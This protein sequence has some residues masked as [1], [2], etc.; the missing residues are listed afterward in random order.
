MRRLQSLKWRRA[1][2]YVGGVSLL[3]LGAYLRFFVFLKFGSGALLVYAAAGAGALLLGV[4]RESS[5]AIKADGLP[6]GAKSLRRTGGHDW[7]S[8]SAAIDVVS[9]GQRTEETCYGERILGYLATL[10]YFYRNPD[11]QMGEYSRM[12]DAE[13]DAQTWAASNKGRTVMVH[14]DPRNP[15]K[16]VLRMEDL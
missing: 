16:S 15:S 6:N 10:T 5:R 9:V 4:G 7:T 8:V 11:L 14:V 3:L 2:G 12:F 1:S 13:N